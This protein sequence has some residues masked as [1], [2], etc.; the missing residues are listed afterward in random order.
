[1]AKSGK[2]KNRYLPQ[3]MGKFIELK[4]RLDVVRFKRIF[5]IER[6]REQQRRQKEI[7]DNEKAQPE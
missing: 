7:E 2:A 1:M 5:Q 3:Q 4:D 6:L